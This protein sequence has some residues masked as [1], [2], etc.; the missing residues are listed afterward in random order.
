MARGQTDDQGRFYLG[1]VPFGARCLVVASEGTSFAASDPVV[2][3]EDGPVAEVSVELGEGETLRGRAVGPDGEPVDG[4]EVRLT[5]DTECYYSTSPIP[6]FTDREGWFAFEGFNP[7][8]PGHYELTVT[9]VRD[10]QPVHVARMQTEGE[11]ETYRLV[12]GLSASGV[13]LEKGSGYPI[14]G[15]TVTARAV[16]RGPAGVSNYL[17]EAPTNEHGEFRFSNLAPGRYSLKFYGGSNPD[18]VFRAGQAEPVEARVQLA[19]WSSLKP[20][21]PE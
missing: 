11:P 2:I 3:D 13:L 21:P 7:D 17:A 18:V 16:G 8:M 15:A 14:P 10:C 5:Y 12:R 20:R 9:P 19:A 4:A 1:P 6:V